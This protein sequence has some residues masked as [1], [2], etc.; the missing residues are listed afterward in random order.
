MSRAEIVRVDAQSLGA[1]D[2]LRL[3]YDLC[4]AAKKYTDERSFGWARDCLLNAQLAAEAYSTLVSAGNNT[5][6]RAE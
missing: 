5:E 2:L 4:Q 6:S 3:I 1:G